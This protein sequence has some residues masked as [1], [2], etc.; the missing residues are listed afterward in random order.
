MNI[1]VASTAS[2]YS[3]VSSEFGEL[4]CFIYRVYPQ[5]EWKWEEL[6]ASQSES[7]A[8]AMIFLMN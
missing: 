8:T 4:K 5:D 7:C 3:S 2:D 6:N 1:P